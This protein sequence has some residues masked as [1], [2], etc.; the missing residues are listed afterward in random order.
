MLEG[1]AES[2][3]KSQPIAGTTV[4]PVLLVV[5]PGEYSSGYF[6]LPDSSG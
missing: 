1:G 3:L 4:S 6:R 2:L 5:G